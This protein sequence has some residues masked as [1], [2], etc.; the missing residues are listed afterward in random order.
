MT[1]ITYSVRVKHHGATTSSGWSVKYPFSMYVSTTAGL[2]FRDD[3]EANLFMS[4]TIIDNPPSASEI[5]NTWPRVDNRTWYS[6]PT[7][8]SGFAS[9]WYYDATTDSFAYPTNVTQSEFILSPDKTDEFQF[10]TVLSSTGADN[11]GIGLVVAG[12][13]ISGNVRMLVLWVHTGGDGSGETPARPKFSLRY[14]DETNA[15]TNTTS[16]YEGMGDIIVGNDAITSTGSW[17]A[18]GDIKVKVSRSGNV[19]TALCTAFGGSTYLPESELTLDISTDLPRNGNTLTGPRRYGFATNSQADANFRDFFITSNDVMDLTSVYS[20]NTN[21]MWNFNAGTW[22]LST[23]NA[24]THFSS[25]DQVINNS[26]KET[27]SI[28][29]T[30]INLFANNGIVSGEVDITATAGTNTDILFSTILSHFPHSVSLNVLEV[31]DFTGMRM[32]SVGTD[33]VTIDTLHG[34]SFYVLIGT[35]DAEFA[36]KTIAFRKVN[37]NVT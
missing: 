23:T 33:K 12:D 22:D 13:Q 17:G 19:V 14:A 15:Q 5:L 30:A 34:G 18:L 16:H 28:K 31:L 32:Y 10:E 36:N 2:M 7:T 24:T 3:K 9:E 26:T 21:T 29:N 4:S 8:A 6:D 27:F 37:V 1:T 35:S 11:D 20:A 25:V